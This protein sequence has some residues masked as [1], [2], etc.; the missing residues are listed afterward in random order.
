MMWSA[1]HTPAGWQVAFDGIPLREVAP[2]ATF[3]AALAYT[4]TATEPYFAT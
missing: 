4:V 1:F 2:F 3:A